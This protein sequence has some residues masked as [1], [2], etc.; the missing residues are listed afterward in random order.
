[1]SQGDV[2]KILKKEKGWINSGEIARKVSISK[3]TV[4][5]NLTKLFNQGDI[6]RKIPKRIDNNPWGLERGSKPYLWKIKG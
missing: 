4:T 5:C 2:L 3:G 6:L 1:M